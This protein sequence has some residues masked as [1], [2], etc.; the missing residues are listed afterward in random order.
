MSSLIAVRQRFT[1]PLS[2]RTFIVAADF[3]KV[4]SSDLGRLGI[5]HRP[6][7]PSVLVS[8]SHEWTD[9]YRR[10]TGGFARKACSQGQPRRTVR[11]MRILQSP[12]L[13]GFT[14]SC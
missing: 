2:L 7:H 4:A 12:C 3:I 5:L 8:I 9:F 6:L 1:R 10:F 14:L 13:Q 11:C